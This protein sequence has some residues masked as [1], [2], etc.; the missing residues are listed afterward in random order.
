MFMN[1]CYETAGFFLTVYYLTLCL[2]L[3]EPIQPSSLLCNCRLYKCV[4][5]LHVMLP[6]HRMA[7]E[8]KGLPFLRI[9]RCL[10]FPLMCL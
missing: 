8:L 9:H 5:L 1:D 2:S 4:K 3:Y 10:C 7:V 6:L